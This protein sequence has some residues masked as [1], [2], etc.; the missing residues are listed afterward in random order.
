[1]TKLEQEILKHLQDGLTRS[2]VVKDLEPLIP[3]LS[4]LGLGTGH[5]AASGGYAAVCQK[6]VDGCKKA[7]KLKEPLKFY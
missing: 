4:E 1:M 5:I 3:R 2:Q 6:F 7:A